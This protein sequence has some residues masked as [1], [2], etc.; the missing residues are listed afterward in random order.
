MSS[1]P[2]CKRCGNY[3]MHGPC[4]CDKCAE[5]T[6]TERDAAMA[7]LAKAEDNIHKTN[8]ANLEL[9]KELARVREQR[10]DLM[11]AAK[12]KSF[13]LMDHLVASIE[14]ALEEER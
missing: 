1:Q 5:K 13:I 8:L 12:D 6:E 14:A 7:A 3:V 2:E 9:Q 10:D 11:R 4:H